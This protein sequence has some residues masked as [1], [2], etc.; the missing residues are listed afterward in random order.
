MTPSARRSHAGSSAPAREPPRRASRSARSRRARRRAA[1]RTGARRRRRRRDQPS[2]WLELA[3]PLPTTTPTTTSRAATESAT[4]TLA[5]AAVRVIPRRLTAVSVS[6]ASARDEPF[7]PDRAGDRVGGERQ[8]HRRAR[9]RLADDEA[10]AR[11]VAPPFAEP[12]AAV[13]VR[14]A[15]GRVLRR[16]LRRGGGV[17][18]R[19]RAGERE[20]EQQAAAGRLGRRREGREDPG[21][22]HRAE[23]DHDGLAGAEAAREGGRPAHIASATRRAAVASSSSGTFG[24][25]S[26][27]RGSIMPLASSIPSGRGTNQTWKC[28]PPS[29]QR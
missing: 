24:S 13:D 19:D 22:D 20:P 12:L 28:A 4:S 10:P 23:A 1:R 6:T 26:S 29:P 15:G 5:S 17:A 21:P 9:R 8:C 11:Q 7:R 27:Q 14:A 16:E 2:R 25:A 18:E 3:S